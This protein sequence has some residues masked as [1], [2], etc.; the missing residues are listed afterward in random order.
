MVNYACSH[1]GL[2]EKGKFYFDLMKEYGIE[3]GD[4][5]YASIVDIYGRANKLQEPLAIIK[6]MPMQP[7]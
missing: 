1:A 7:T 4:Q 3:P 2:V 6:E 5:H